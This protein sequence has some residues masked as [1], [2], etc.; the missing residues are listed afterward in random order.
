MVR[1]CPHCHATF[2]ADETLSCCMHGSVSVTIPVVP[3]RM[4]SII[5]T[6]VVLKNIRVYN[7]ALS[8]ASTGHA[9]LSPGWGM[10]VMGGKAYHRMSARFVSSTGTPGFAQIYMLDTSA[11]T[12][13]RWI[14]KQFMMAP[15][16]QAQQAAARAAWMTQTSS[17]RTYWTTTT[18]RMNSRCCSACSRR[19][20]SRNHAEAQEQLLQPRSLERARHANVIKHLHTRTVGRASS[21]LTTQTSQLTLQN[22]YLT[23]SI[24]I[25]RRPA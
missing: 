5:T 15:P 11:A 7:M 1:L 14:W 20:S 22:T 18:L 6:P 19:H 3:A 21:H 16:V 17:S 23:R 13:R 24:A 2:F 4:T 9:N 25:N 8:M 10:F 12:A